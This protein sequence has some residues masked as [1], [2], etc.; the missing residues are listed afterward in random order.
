[1]LRHM[2]LNLRNNVQEEGLEPTAG[3]REQEPLLDT[4]VTEN[5][6]MRAAVSVV[7]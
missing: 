1:M 6:I 5:I 3:L 7:S 4:Y 2:I